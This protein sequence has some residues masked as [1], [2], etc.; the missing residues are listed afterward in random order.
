MKLSKVATSTLATMKAGA[1]LLVTRERCSVCGETVPRKV[2]DELL[3][4]E[5]IVFSHKPNNFS[6]AYTPVN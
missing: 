6:R 3:S 5:A 2:F 4:A 1:I